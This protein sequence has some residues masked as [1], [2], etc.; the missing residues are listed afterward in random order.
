MEI[1]VTLIMLVA[2]GALV[3]GSSRF[4]GI[5][6]ASRWLSFA[7]FVLFGVI[8]LASLYFMFILD[9]Q[10]GGV[11][12]LLAVPAGLVSALFFI[13]FT[14]SL[15]AESLLAL[16]LEQQLEQTQTGIDDEIRKLEQRIASAQARAGRFWSTAATRERL[17]QN[18]GRDQFMLAELRKL[19]TALKTRSP[20]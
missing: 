6:L 9:N 20:S 14:A 4:R 1:L 18:I 17:R 10:G 13:G 2:L 11:L 15:G 5:R 3:L 7:G 12:L 19:Q 8:A 16:P